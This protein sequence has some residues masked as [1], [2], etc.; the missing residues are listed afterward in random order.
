M[1]NG[2]N[3]INIPM[4]DVTMYRQAPSAALVR[5]HQYKYKIHHF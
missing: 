3:R 4:N 2:K 1:E 5:I